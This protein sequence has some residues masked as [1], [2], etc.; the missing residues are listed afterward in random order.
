MNYKKIVFLTFFYI[1]VKFFIRFE[2]R[3]YNYK[4]EI[5]FL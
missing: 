1:V 2:I 4:I 5:L 3:N